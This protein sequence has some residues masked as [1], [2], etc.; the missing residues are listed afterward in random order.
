MFWNSKHKKAEKIILF[1][2]WE[3]HW[4]FLNLK[5]SADTYET[6]LKMRK[7]DLKS[8]ALVRDWGDVG[9]SHCR[10]LHKLPSA[11]DKFYSCFPPA[12]L[13]Y[14]WSF[15]PLRFIC[16][17]CGL[18]CTETASYNCQGLCLPQPHLSTNVK[19]IIIVCHCCNSYCLCV[20]L[21]ERD[22]TDRSREKPYSCRSRAVPLLSVHQDKLP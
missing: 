18:F 3:H 9:Y 1:S 8:T 16:L 6:I 10:G 13:R 22:S 12:K 19:H 11:K 20:K 5:V 7:K 17:G 4:R 14:E 15:F 21:S 2:L